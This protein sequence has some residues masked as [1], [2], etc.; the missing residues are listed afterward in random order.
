MTDFSNDPIPTSMVG[1]VNYRSLVTKFL[2]VKS[3]RVGNVL[4][5]CS[6]TQEPYGEVQ[7]VA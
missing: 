3:S 6:S 2:E 7:L 4:S 5:V 1:R